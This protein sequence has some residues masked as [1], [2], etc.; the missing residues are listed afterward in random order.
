MSHDGHWGG[1]DN[2]LELKLHRDGTAVT[3]N[4]GFSKT[5]SH[6]KYKVEDDGTIIVTE[7]GD[8]PSLAMPWAIE[9]G[10]LVI[11]PPAKELLFEAARKYGIAE[12]ELTDEAY[13]E[14][15]ERW[16]LRQIDRK[17]LGVTKR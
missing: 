2:D 16:P 4:F 10:K 3:T 5:I 14:S 17:K 9:N 15:Y 6:G 12:S 1:T 7:C 11:R 13:E 8:I